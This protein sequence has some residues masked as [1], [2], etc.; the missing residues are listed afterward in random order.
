MNP[1]L[2]TSIIYGETTKNTNN[3]ESNIMGESYKYYACYGNGNSLY[4]KTP[5][6]TQKAIQKTIRQDASLYTANLAPFHVYKNN[7]SV[8]WNQMSD[9]PIPSVQ[10]ASVPTGVNCSLNS[11]HNSV[12]SSRPG[13][14]TPGGIGCDIKHNSYDR[15]L[16][17]LK[18]KTGAG[19]AQKVSASFT[20]SQPFNRANPVYGNK[21]IKTSLISGCEY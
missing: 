14:Q 18:G 5:Y 15:F 21:I 9:R 4:K 10:N 6:Q 11:R 2:Q 17:R 13:C 16:N 12:T 1:D 7:T 8:C 3:L 19:R 20:N